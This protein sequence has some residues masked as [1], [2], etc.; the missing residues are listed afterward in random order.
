M[1]LIVYL[2]FRP[3]GDALS[4]LQLEAFYMARRKLAS[5]LRYCGLAGFD[6]G[7][8]GVW[9]LEEHVTDPGIGSTLLS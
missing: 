6:A 8:S 9:S 2:T 7:A 4:R 1:R 5:H 3:W